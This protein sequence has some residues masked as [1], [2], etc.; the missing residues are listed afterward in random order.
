M[1]FMFFSD[2]KILTGHKDNRSIKRFL[3]ELRVPV[4][5]IGRRAAVD[6]MVFEKR[7]EKHYRL[8]ICK[9]QYVPTLETEKQFHADLQKL[10]TDSTTGHRP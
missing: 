8:T 10:L 5:Y 7:M 9:T 4:L 6:K 1:E 3:S 2:I